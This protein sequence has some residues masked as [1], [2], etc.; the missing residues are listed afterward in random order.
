MTDTDYE[1][2]ND[3]LLDL[4]HTDEP[5][6]VVVEGNKFTLDP[7]E[8]KE[9]ISDY[10][11]DAYSQESMRAAKSLEA[12]RYCEYSCGFVKESK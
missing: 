2:L 4:P 3:L 9:F 10:G 7:R 11:R 6:E 1:E 8:A 12:M 5:V